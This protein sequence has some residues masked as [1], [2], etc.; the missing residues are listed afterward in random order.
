MN[1]DDLFSFE[2]TA[3][4]YKLTRYLMSD[5]AGITEIGIP[6]EY[7]SEPVSAIGHNAFSGS[8]H[9]YCVKIPDSV[10]L[11][12]YG[13]FS[14]CTGLAEIKLP[15][16]L[17]CISAFTFSGCVSLKSA[18]IPD[19]VTVIFDDAFSGCVSLEEIV[20]PKRLRS[21]DGAFEGC[22]NLRSVVFQSEDVYVNMYEFIDCPALPPETVMRALVP[23]SDITEP[24]VYSDDEGF[25]WETAL[26]RDVFELAVRYD[27][28]SKTDK[29]LLFYMLFS[30]EMFVEYYPIMS[31]SGWLYREENTA[32]FENMISEIF[33][34]ECRD[35]PELWMNMDVWVT[36]EK[37]LGGI[38]S[39]AARAGKM[40]G[41]RTFFDRLI[42]YSARFGR[43][44]AAAYLLEYKRRKF[45]FDGDKKYEL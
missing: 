7:R 39:A 26:R 9:L 20:L 24:F 37:L 34:G 22:T 38:L 41:E 2:K 10:K 21:L 31:G 17:Y 3:D 30:E 27:S 29:P 25:N 14:K 16:K 28:F 40:S 44:E 15:R 45:G 18:V 8:K 4:G 12:D 11:I 43:T 32:G 13:A 5:N 35:E 36:D 23:G 6:A 33:D 19:D 1:C 42:E